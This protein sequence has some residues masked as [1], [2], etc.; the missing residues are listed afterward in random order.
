M[1]IKWAMNP[2]DSI[3]S[4][5]FTNSQ[6]GPEAKN[7]LNLNVVKVVTHAIYGASA[8]TAGNYGNLFT[9]DKA[10]AL[11]GV[12]AVWRVASSSGT[13]DIEKCGSGVAPDSGTALLS[14]TINLAG[15]ANTPVHATLTRTKRNLLLKR[16][17]RLVAKDG[18]TLT[19]QDDL[20]ITLYLLQL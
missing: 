20:H 18:G 11:I 17:D 19:S 5:P 14:S 3:N 4:I 15:A 1:G 8:A 13:L 7:I 2:D 12:S 16:G 9:A 6:L 10:Y